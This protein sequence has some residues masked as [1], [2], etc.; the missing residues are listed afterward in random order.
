MMGRVGERMVVGRVGGREG[1][2]RGMGEGRWG[3]V[4][5]G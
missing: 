4:G 5:G 2:G 1:G 3:K